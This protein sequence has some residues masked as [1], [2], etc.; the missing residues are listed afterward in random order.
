[1]NSTITEYSFDGLWL[2]I[3]TIPGI[4][5]QKSDVR[6]P[7]SE[8]VAEETLTIYLRSTFWKFVPRASRPATGSRDVQVSL[9][10]EKVQ[11]I[12]PA[13][14][15]AAKTPILQLLRLYTR[16]NAEYHPTQVAIILVSYLRLE[17]IGSFRG[18]TPK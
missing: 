8:G 18:V 5:G 2:I 10:L 11:P 4:L 1:M 6:H 7:K 14:S 3:P 9:S 17:K 12:R 13:T 15:S 16:S